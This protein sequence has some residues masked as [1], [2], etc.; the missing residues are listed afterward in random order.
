MDDIPKHLREKGESPETVGGRHG[1]PEGV[2][3]ILGWSMLLAVVALI[4]AALVV[5]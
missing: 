3:R 2:W 5:G 4:A 1:R